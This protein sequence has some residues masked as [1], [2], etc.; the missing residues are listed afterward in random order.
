VSKNFAAKVPNR[1]CDVANKSFSRR[2]NSMTSLAELADNAPCIV[3]VARTPMGG[4]NGS[5]STIPAPELGA[6]AMKAA[7]ER[8]GVKCDAIDEVYMG[9]VL[10]AGLGQNPARQAALFAGISKFTPATTVNKVCAS[11]LKAVAL[12]AQ[13]IRLGEAH[14]VIAGGFESMSRSP[15]CIPALRNGVKYGAAQIIDTLQ[16]DGLTNPVGPY[17]DRLMG[18]CGELCASTY[19]FSR[20]DQD[21]FAARSYL[22]AH[23]AR[24]AGKFDGEIQQVEVKNRR[25]PP[26]LVS[27]DEESLSRG[28]MTVEALGKL[29][30]AF[31]KNGS[32]TAG[33]SSTISDG[34]AALVIT[35]AKKAREL[36]LNVLAVIAG[37]A[38]AAH[39]A[40]MFTTAPALAVPIALKR[41]GIPMQE[42]DFFELNEAFAVVGCVNIKLLNLNPEKVNVYG[43][44]VSMGHPLGCSGARILIT[45]LSVLRNEGGM[46]GCAGV[47]N[48]GGGA[49]ALVIRRLA[50]PPGS[51]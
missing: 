18:D 2:M 31:E 32:V 24:E 36:K 34:G 27:A 19:K 30:P 15:H 22:R 8:A 17:K 5:L 39:D 25:G 10:Q 14:I 26:T 43:G 1:I 3:G 6:I 40:E 23:K 47:C 48:G 29:R 28:P 49:T 11:G 9:N 35:S 4:L 44:A 13:A 45:L 20:E 51:L 38:D 12:A 50:S 42:V 21:K 7:M 16:H 33:N 41:S 46:I 37:A